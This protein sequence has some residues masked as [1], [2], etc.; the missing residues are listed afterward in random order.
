MSLAKTFCISLIGLTGTLIE[1]EADISSNLP[2][3]VLVGLPDASLSEAT[4]R[5]RAATAN[6]K[7]PLPNRK[8]TVNLSPASVPKFGSVFDL[9]I[10][11]AALAAA[12]KVTDESIAGTVYFGELGL[13][14]SIRPVSG[15]L[16][17][18]M[19]AK[20]E[21]FRRVVVPMSNLAEAKLI[22]GI[23]AIG[24]S[25]LTQVLSM[26][27]LEIQV[28]DSPVRDSSDQQI[29][30]PAKIDISEIHGQD[31]VVESMIVAAAG[32]HH[33]LMVGPP[34]VGKTMMAE[35]LTTIL[36]DL[37]LEQS[38]ETTAIHSVSK[39]RG[40]VGANLITR[41]PFEAPHHTASAS[42]LVGGGLG[43][44]SPGLISLA[45]N[46][47]LFLDEAPEFQTPTLESLRQAL[48][49]GQV[50]LARSAGIATFPARF[51][52][53]LAANPCPC[54]H[55]MTVN[56]NCTC[57]AH[58]KNRYLNRLSGPLLDRIDIRLKVRPVNAAQ[59]EI[60]RQNSNRVS[61][62]Q[63]KARVISARSQL[64]ER[65]S[66]LGYQ[67]VTHVPPNQLRSVVRPSKSATRSIDGA[68]ARGGLSM[69]GYDRC[70]RIGLTV[71][72]LDGRDEIQAS[73]LD[74]AFLLRGSDEVMVAA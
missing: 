6:S 8:V 31:A 5:V 9:A 57:S 21:G 54:G 61:S 30:V 1:V 64:M 17:A 23:E 47:V 45:H 34:G 38:L 22:E 35:R 66:P 43:T 52:L 50:S 7:A 28:V 53:V 32:G 46:G 36:P 63:A 16:P 39:V 65:L 29:T 74:Q 59:V 15:V 27:G 55:A 69:R 41:P 12:G 73:D 44:P 72:A 24:A 56:R 13:D 14:G 68:L 42:S 11:I 48:E 19:S 60:S 33:M 2:G 3:F 40:R 25:H 10:A 26:H 62:S 4:A 67:L 71:A 18:V 51:Q 37:S 20:R 58:S 49:K 70:I